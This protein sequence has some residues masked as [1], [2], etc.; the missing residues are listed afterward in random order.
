MDALLLEERVSEV[1]EHKPTRMGVPPAPDPRA[2]IAQLTLNSLHKHLEK[3]TDPLK[4]GRL[5]YE[6]AR[7][8]E[9]PLGDLAKAGDHYQQAY[10]L[11]PDHVPTLRGTRRV[12]LARREF[13]QGLAL[14]DAEA[15]F[16]GQPASRAVL[17]YEKARVLEDHMGQRRE[18]R[19]A[20]A[21]ALELDPTLST[22]LKAIERLDLAEQLW[23]AL[24]GTYEREASAAAE[25][26]RLRA[27]ILAERA[28]LAEKHKADT[29]AASEL[30]RE[31]LSFDQAAPGAI[32][33]LKRLFTGSRRYRD[34]AETLR[35]EAMLAADPGVRSM[36]FYLMGR[37]LVDRL[38]HDDEA[39]AAFERAAESAPDE[40]LVL[41]QLER[42]YDRTKRYPELVQT[43]SRMVERAE[44][45]S[46]QLGL[47]HRIGQIW[48]EHLNDETQAISSYAK[49]LALDPAYQ[50][51][52]SALGTLYTRRKEWQPLIA[53]HGAEAEAV[54]DAL[55]R[56]AAHA[57]I[58]VIC[59]E[60][61]GQTDAAMAQHARALGLSPMYPTSFK[62]LARLYSGA[63]KFRELAEL[64]QR[65][66]DAAKDPETKITYLFK[67]GR[68]F[69]D[70]LDSASSALGAYRRVLEVD[71]QHVGALHAMQRAAERAGRYKDL[72]L[73]LETEAKIVSDPESQVGLLHRAGEV[74]EDHLG[75]SD[76]ALARFADVVKK[77]PR[78]APALSSLGRLY[79]R[80]GRWDELL[81]VY[82]KELSIT[83]KGPPSAA[84]LYK[85]AELTEER[86]GKD[87]DAL[88]LYRRAIE[89]DP[90]H[91][92]A[93]HAL[94][95]M[96]AAKGSW[97]ELVKLIELELSGLKD[98]ELRAR[99]AL[100]LAEVYENRLS[101]NDKALAAYEQALAADPAFRPALDGRARLLSLAKDWKQYCEELEREI[102]G[103]A[104]PTVAVAARFRQAE[105]LRDEL[106]DDKRA[107][108]A[109]EDVLRRDP[110][111]LGALRALEPLYTKG[112]NFDGLAQVYTRQAA[113]ITDVGAKVAALR[114]L[115]RLQEGRSKGGLEAER[116][117]YIS[118]LQLAPSDP[119]ALAQLERIALAMH[120]SQ[121]MTHVD[122]KLGTTSV[123]AEVASA[124]QT[125]LA[126]MLEAI[127]DSSALES[128][129]A[130]LARDPENMGAAWGIVRLARSA[131]D[132]E[133]LESAAD[134]A[135]RA[136]ED[137]TVAGELLR[138]AADLHAGRGNADKAVA[139]LQHALEL[140]PDDDKVADELEHLLLALGQ[141]D[142][143]FDAL[144]QAAQWATNWDRRA[145]L[146]IRVSRL[147]ADKKNDLPA[148]LAALHRV[149]EEQP[150]HVVTLMELGRLYARD[151]QW[152]EAVD[153][154][155]QVLAQQPAKELQ[156]EAHSEL[157]RI[158]QDHLGDEARAMVSVE[159]VLSLD[160][161][162]RPGL[163][164]MATI[165]KR[166]G[167]HGPA[168]ETA[169]R[170]VQIAR[171]DHERAEA[172]CALAIL[173]R[174]QKSLDRAA[175]AYEQ[176]VALIG[177]DG[178]AGQDFHD[179]LVEQKL[180]GEDPH[181]SNYVSALKAY[182]EGGTRTPQARLE[183]LTEIARV[184]GDELHQ[185]DAAI[186]TLDQALAQTPASKELRIEL[187]G[188]LRAAGNNERALGELK[189]LLRLD[190]TR[191]ETWRDLSQVYKAL[192][193]K[194]ESELAAGPLVALGAA[195][196]L[197]RAT[198]AAR[199][200]RMARAQQGAFDSAAYRALDE[201][202]GADS[203]HEL[204]AAVSEGLAKVHPPE[205]ERYGLS[206]RDRV[207][208]RS[209]NPLRILAEHVGH[210][211]GVTDFD[212]YVHRAHAGALEVELTDPPAVLVPANVTNLSEVEQAFLL[213]RPLCNISRRLHATNR[214]SPREVEL[215][216]VAATRA[217]DPSFGVGIA[218][219]DFLQSHA[220][221]VQKSL[222]RRGRRAAEEAALIYAGAKRVDF[223]ELS[224]RTR[225][226]AARAA[227]VFAD[228]LPAC[229]TLIRRTEG[230]LAG[231]RGQALAQGMELAADLM[232]FWIG[233]AAH[234]LRRRLGYG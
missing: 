176:A 46:A 68:L 108:E 156:I 42:L 109:F 100:R 39:V 190:V 155:N 99:T 130:A 111:H 56:A 149:I 103:A 122:A 162:N 197:E 191:A 112:G 157:A 11:C 147:L 173:E 86:L 160:A 27:A 194:E 94:G 163:I 105:I 125:R 137:A 151:R 62:A 48:E 17:L 49:A 203:A 80:A 3:V 8:Y 1:A 152:A 22:A 35:T 87:D 31:A 223:T 159:R 23:D 64:Y 195:N 14:F 206:T 171:D 20:Y 50:P 30:Y 117:S 9:S 154:F 187:V 230:D 16:T 128:Y 76:G 74:L 114:E 131:S 226:S 127:G 37:V 91:Q 145:D 63:G 75:D 177:L 146:W 84:L 201:H 38:G 29:H 123:V 229:V 204:L 44:S 189:H 72:V 214:L 70:A 26:K 118:I 172:L 124:H 79:Y 57:R 71:P 126:E 32:D 167:Q 221:K 28:H 107:V 161:S 148:A 232:R 196:D 61:L 40:L 110:A 54:D 183:V 98:P 10:Q 12:L 185:I 24:D 153:R 78:Y 227:L 101:Q 178:R 209:G 198:L 224:E 219:E 144:C 104:D 208:S 115:A 19:D 175:H 33:A 13:S 92:P 116:A 222:S 200:S 102:A 90:F 181:W 5:H 231:L 55:R 182:L 217:V 129:R 170:L 234:T 25:D 138:R 164:R 132:P 36:A 47:Y 73:A 168:A 52:L 106:E 135:N 143:L 166:R 69:E 136:L 65:A 134:V 83:P 82:A 7:L 119:G 21:A 81:E 45:K 140:A 169:A 210:V 133:Q 85:M 43:L 192:G 207:T 213:A 97:A 158:L 60:Q 186:G 120:D 216:L 174:E 142:R 212:L 184:Q 150:G 4:R 59:E 15:R 113:V 202:G 225:R 180:L 51:S 193:R 179:L 199:P 121:L 220:R 96:L 18:A 211:F 2:E 89:M 66:V 228:D 205:L 58:A 53:M 88:A 95:R 218:D 139:V 165:Q 188:R 6:L 34:L 41:G 233:D 77:N 215:L 93:L 141:V 67:I